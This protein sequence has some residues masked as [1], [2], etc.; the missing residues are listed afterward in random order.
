MSPA[1]FVGLSVPADT[2]T[3]PGGVTVVTA[4]TPSEVKPGD[5]LLM[6]VT[7]LSQVQVDTARVG[8]GWS[9]IGR[10]VGGDSALQVCRRIVT[11][12]E[13]ATHSLYLR[14]NSP[15]TPLLMAYRG[16][17]PSMGVIGIASDA[18]PA[19]PPAEYDCHTQTLT[20]YSDVYFGVAMSLGTDPFLR[21]WPTQNIRYNDTQTQFGQ[22]TTLCVFDYYPEAAGA[23][24]VRLLNQDAVQG[25]YG[26]FALKA[27]PAP[28]AKMLNA[29]VPGAI[30]LP[31]IGV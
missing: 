9:S 19:G 6:I 5:T 28:R 29:D 22:Q 21:F 17:D 26:S 1:M 18:K 15:C 16:L 31:T 12:D 20:A 3:G 4:L 30:G 8:P 10:A 14:S 25:M 2:T 11:D 24:G 7:A 13:P 27:L 23:T